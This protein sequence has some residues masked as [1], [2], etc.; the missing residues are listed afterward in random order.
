MN[1]M[2]LPICFSDSLLRFLWLD[3][4][5]IIDLFMIWLIWLQSQLTN[6]FYI[7]SHWFF[8][9]SFFPLPVTAKHFLLI[10][11]WLFYVFIIRLKTCS[12][13]R[14]TKLLPFQLAVKWA[15]NFTTMKLFALSTFHVGQNEKKTETFTATNGKRKKFEQTTQKGLTSGS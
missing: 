8:F 4:W 10:F 5:V 1:Q 6:K 13:T 7:F 14:K 11:T 2:N 15:L 12:K 9:C 3:I